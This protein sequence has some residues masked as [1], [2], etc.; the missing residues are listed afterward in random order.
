MDWNGDELIARGRRAT[1]RGVIGIGSKTADYAKTFV[2]VISG[3]LMR[4]I[5]LAKSGTS[6]RG[7]MRRGS[8]AQ[9]GDKDQFLLDVGSWLDYACVEEVGRGHQFMQPAVEAVMGAVA[10]S[11]MKAAWEAEG[12]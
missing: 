9:T 3:D 8:D 12:L 7:A 2:D 5:T 6:G 4:S 10:F 11:I 1:G